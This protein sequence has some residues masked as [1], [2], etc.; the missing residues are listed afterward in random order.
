MFF[1]RVAWR[2]KEEMRRDQRGSVFVMLYCWR[3]SGSGCFPSAEGK[4]ES[5]SRSSGFIG[6]RLALGKAKKVP[7]ERE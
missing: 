6:S 7:R 3:G 5:Q 2:R 1:T 4:K